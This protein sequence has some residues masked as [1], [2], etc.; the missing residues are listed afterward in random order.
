MAVESRLSMK[1]F[2]M[3]LGA[4]LVVALALSVFGYLSNRNTQTPAERESDVTSI[5]K[6]IARDLEADYPNT[7]RKVIDLYSQITKSLYD[8]KLSEEDLKLL[9]SQSRKLMDEQLLL[10][11][12]EDTF[13]ENTKAAIEEYQSLKR[14]VTSYVLEDSNSVEYYTENGEE[15]ASI[16]VKYY[17][18]DKNGYGKTYE[19]FMLRKDEEGRWKIVGWQVTSADSDEDE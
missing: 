18:N 13:L 17:L 19:D 2:R 9:C 7:P 15:F 8:S 5:G 4:F 12:P 1:K 14:V 3:A 10:L 6:L 16:S 11:N